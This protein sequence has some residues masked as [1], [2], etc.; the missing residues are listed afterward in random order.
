MEEKHVAVIGPGSEAR[1][2]IS[3]LLTVQDG[4]VTFTDKEAQEKLNEACEKMTTAL[5]NVFGNFSELAEKVRATITYLMLDADFE[6]RFERLKR[7]ADQQKEFKYM[8]FDKK[9]K[10]CKKDRFYK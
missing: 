8:S 9:N 4:K 6:R 7:I 10:P 2:T 5:N 3:V 1:K